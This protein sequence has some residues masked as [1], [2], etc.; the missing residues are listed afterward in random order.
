MSWRKLIKQV[1]SRIQSHVEAKE[2]Q[3]QM[4]QMQRARDHFK[5][6]KGFHKG[7]EKV[8]K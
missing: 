3:K 6:N 2:I 5:N 1:A 4:D 7:F 8:K